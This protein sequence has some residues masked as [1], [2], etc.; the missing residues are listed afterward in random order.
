M[1]RISVISS[2][3]IALSMPALALAAPVQDSAIPT[4]TS[5]LI[6][7]RA[8]SD[9]MSPKVGQSPVESDGRAPLPLED[10]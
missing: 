8:P 4:F 2:L 7:A 5:G 3:T 10:L 1:A 9:S 6:Q